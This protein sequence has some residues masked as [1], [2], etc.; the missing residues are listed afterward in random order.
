MPRF[1]RQP[2]SSPEER[3][4]QACQTGNRASAE[5]A[6]EEIVSEGVVEHLLG[7]DLPFL[8]ACAHERWNIVDLLLQYRNEPAFFSDPKALESRPAS[9]SP[10]RLEEVLLRDILRGLSRR[11]AAPPAALMVHIET[12]Q[13]RIADGVGPDHVV[14]HSLGVLPGC[15]AKYAQPW[16][17]RWGGK[18]QQ[19]MPGGELCL[20]ELAGQ[21]ACPAALQALLRHGARTDWKDHVGRTV[22]DNLAYAQ[23]GEIKSWMTG[24]AQQTA[25]LANFRRRGA[26]LAFLQQH[27]AFT[28]AWRDPEGR[29]ATECFALRGMDQIGDDTIKALIQAETLEQALPESEVIR[30]RAR[31]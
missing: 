4:I 14:W 26:N 29:T 22:V 27:D 18:A 25:T 9:D 12:L 17:E 31:L 10:P 5:R 3:L 16:L 23:R 7:G 6:I 21:L 13:T 11:R 30:P 20:L 8:L 24:E 1:S 2:K 28:R 15:L 19:W